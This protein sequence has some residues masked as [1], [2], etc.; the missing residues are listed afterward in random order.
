MSTYKVGWTTQ[1]K[2]DYKRAIK[3]G[4]PIELLDGVIREL[5]NDEALPASMRDHELTGNFE[6]V[7]E[8]HIEPDWLLVY[9]KKDDLLVLSLMRT[10]SHSDLF[11]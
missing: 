4:K 5:A 9:E 6:G 3:R 1:F 8:C 2:K 10:G 11:G 7:R